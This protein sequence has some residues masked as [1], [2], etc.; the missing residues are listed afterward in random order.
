VD[1]YERG[2]AT[3]AKVQF[4]DSV[5][6]AATVDTIL[7]SKYSPTVVAA[8]RVASVTTRGACEVLHCLDYNNAL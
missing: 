1:V 4:A 8:A 3:P 2:I 6:H 7:K 5:R